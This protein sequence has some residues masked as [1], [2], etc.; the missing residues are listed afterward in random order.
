[1]LSEEPQAVGRRALERLRQERAAEFVSWVSIGGSDLDERDVDAFGAT[2]FVARETRARQR[3]LATAVMR[4]GDVKARGSRNLID[5]L[6]VGAGMWVL[7]RL[8]TERMEEVFYTAGQ[9]WWQAPSGGWE[10]DK[11]SRCRPGYRDAGD[12][13]L[14]LEALDALITIE[15]STPGLEVRGTS[16]VLIQARADLRLIEDRLDAFLDLG[17]GRRRAKGWFENAPVKLWVDDSGL[18]WRVSYAPMAVNATQPFWRTI[19]LFAFGAPSC[20]PLLP[21]RQPA[22]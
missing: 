3:R 21:S 1:M 4:D 11:R 9:R 8:H 15:E 22:A 7:H 14:V 2:N 19:E 13:A 20:S 16:T 12:P 18:P 5:K 6:L 17:D 10:T